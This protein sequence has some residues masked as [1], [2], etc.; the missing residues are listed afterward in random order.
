MTQF[1][2]LMGS[3]TQRGGRVN[4]RCGGNTQDYATLVASLP[5]GKIIEKAQTGNTNP[6]SSI[7]VPAFVKV[8]MSSQREDR[9]TNYSFYSR[10]SLHV[11]KCFCFGQRPLVPWYVFKFL[12]YNHHGN[13][14]RFTNRYSFQ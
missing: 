11:S 1:L 6:V 12:F 5:D 4:I 3:L 13:W 10:S 14:N 7:S 2:N 8:L 9:N